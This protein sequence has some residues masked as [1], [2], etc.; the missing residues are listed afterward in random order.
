MQDDKNAV[1]IFVIWY[2]DVYGHWTFNGAWPGKEN[3]KGTYKRAL[4]RVRALN[5]KYP[6]GP[7]E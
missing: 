6:N 5:R 7:K 2:N 3:F 4:A 1:N